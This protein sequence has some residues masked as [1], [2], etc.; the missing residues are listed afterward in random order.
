MTLCSCLM[1]ALN[2]LSILAKLITILFYIPTSAYIHLWITY[3]LLCYLSLNLVI[4]TTITI[5]VLIILI[6]VESGMLNYI[7]NYLNYRENY[8][9][10]NNY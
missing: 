5:T 2:P 10:D 6:F 3:I 4:T 8:L 9:N 7:N 1:I